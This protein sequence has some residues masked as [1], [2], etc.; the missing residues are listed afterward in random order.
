MSSGSGGASAY[1]VIVSP[2]DNPVLELE[3][4][5][6]VVARPSWPPAEWVWGWTYASGSVIWSIGF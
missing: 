6:R 5:A 2:L 3:T 4:W 1:F